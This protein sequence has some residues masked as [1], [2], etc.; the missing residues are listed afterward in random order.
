MHCILTTLV[1]YTSVLC[2]IKDTVDNFA[3]IF[4]PSLKWL[5]LLIFVFNL[6]NMSNAVDL[7]Y[8]NMATAN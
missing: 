5:P 1:I 3:Y 6:I 7:A 4:K 2:R 8:A